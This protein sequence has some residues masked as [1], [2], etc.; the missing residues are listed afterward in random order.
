MS[1][2]ETTSGEAGGYY[3]LP[4]P[5]P[6]PP[7]AL[8]GRIWI[9]HIQIRP[10]TA[11]GGAGVGGGGSSTHVHRP[12]PYWVGPGKSVF[13]SLSRK[14]HQK[15]VI[16]WGTPFFRTYLARL[17]EIFTKIVYFLGPARNDRWR[18]VGT[19]PSS[20]HTSP[21]RGPPRTYLGQLHPNTSSEG[22]WRGW[23][24]RGRG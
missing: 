12:R 10:R 17:R 15:G 19:T 24:G 4:P 21:A 13:F 9:S 11:P 7:G 23:C 14:M 18:H 5:T 3:P 8:R 20:G 16:F 6:A 2:P 22:P 1:Q